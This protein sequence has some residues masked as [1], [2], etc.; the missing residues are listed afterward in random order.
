MTPIVDR[1]SRSPIAKWRLLKVTDRE[2]EFVAKDTKAKLLVPMRC[3]LSEFLRLLVP[4]VPDVYRHA[5]RYFG[6]LAPRAKGRAYAGLFMVL[7]QTRRPRPQRLSWRSSL[8][9]YC[10]RDPLVDSHGHAMGWVRQE[11]AVRL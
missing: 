7:G 10:G 2:V 9:K 3:R 5:I 4:H 11:R 6:L 1:R 8:L